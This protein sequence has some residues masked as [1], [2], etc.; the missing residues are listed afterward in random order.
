MVPISLPYVGGRVPDRRRA[1]LAQVAWRRRIDDLPGQGYIIMLGGSSVCPR[2]RCQRQISL[3]H[4]SYGFPGDAAIPRAEWRVSSSAATMNLPSLPQFH[5]PAAGPGPDGPIRGLSKYGLW[6]CV[7]A[8]VPYN[9]QLRVFPQ[10]A[11]IGAF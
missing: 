5:Y 2:R 3:C 1:D 4:S 6:L 7:P 10:L 9:W 11:Y 8:Y